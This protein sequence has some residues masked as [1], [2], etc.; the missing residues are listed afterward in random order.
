MSDWGPAERDWHHTGSDRDYAGATGTDWEH[1]GQKWEELGATETVLGANCII[2][3][4][5]WE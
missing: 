1:T 3:E 2:M 4:N 5:D